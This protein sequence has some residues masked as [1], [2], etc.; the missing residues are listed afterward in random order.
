[1]GK[2]VHVWINNMF[3]VALQ[4]GMPYGW[5]TNWIKHLHK[6]GDISNHHGWLANN[7]TIWM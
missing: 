3:N 1:M 6:G 5:S 4:R 2:E 7:K